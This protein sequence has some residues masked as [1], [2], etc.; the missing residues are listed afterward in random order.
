MKAHV[1]EAK[2]NEVADIKRLIKEYPVMVIVNMENLP[3]RNLLKIKNSLRGKVIIKYS[4]KRLM[5]IAFDQ[6]K[7]EKKNIVNLKE[8]FKGVPALL[9]TKENPFSLQKLLNKNKSSTAAKAGQ[10]APY[11]LIV[12]AGPTPFT[13]G[14]M[15]GELGILGIKT[16]VEGGK[17]SILSD[18]ILVEKDKEISFKAAELLTK[19]G[20][21]PMEIGLNLV[22]AYQDGEI[23]I[24]EVL[25]IDEKV[26]LQNIIK[27]YCDSIALATSIGYPTKETIEILIKQAYIQAKSVSKVSGM[28]TSEIASEHIT[29]AERE[30]IALKEKIPGKI[31]AQD[32]Q[33]VGGD[34]S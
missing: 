15:I 19:L 9:F 8:K 26:Y 14:P 21:E 3:A 11:D 31:D 25:D 23:L 28:L 4:K 24:K 7:D 12:P 2:K 18:K 33:K 16:K 27:A 13:P 22:V 1:T 34:N 30:M 10:I 5:K 32:S 20:I 17:I 6:L 29:Q